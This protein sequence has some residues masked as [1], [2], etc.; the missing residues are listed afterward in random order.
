MS[1]GVAVR[2]FMENEADLEN[3]F[4]TLTMGGEGGK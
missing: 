2:W 3:V 1:H 4:M